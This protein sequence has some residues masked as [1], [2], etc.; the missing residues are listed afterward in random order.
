[1]PSIAYI[2]IYTKGHSVSGD[3]DRDFKIG[4][5]AGAVG[6]GQY[7]TDETMSRIIWMTLVNGH[8]IYN[9]PLLGRLDYD[10]WDDSNHV[11]YCYKVGH[12]LDLGPVDAVLEAAGV[13]KDVLPKS[14]NRWV[15]DTPAGRALL[16]Y[17]ASRVT[18]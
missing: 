15:K 18:P 11:W 10:P 6:C 1:M 3:P 14:Q 7:F 8:L 16:A 13:T 4:V 5:E 12:H 2:P 17:A 9:G